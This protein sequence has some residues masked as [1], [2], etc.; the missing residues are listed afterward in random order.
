MSNTN[1]LAVTDSKPLLATAVNNL[2]SKHAR[3]KPTKDREYYYDISTCPQ[4][5]TQVHFQ[6]RI[7]PPT[8]RVRFLGIDGGGSRGV[9]S[10]AFMEEL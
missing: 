6:A 7:L 10:L 4:C 2:S 5:R 1:S 8:C 9:V 3:R